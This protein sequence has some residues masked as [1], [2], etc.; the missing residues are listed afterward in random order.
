MSTVCSLKTSTLGN[1]LT[2]YNIVINA[3][4]LHENAELF[5]CGRDV[6]PCGGGM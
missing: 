4:G 1:W 5:A 2:R 3:A 6:T